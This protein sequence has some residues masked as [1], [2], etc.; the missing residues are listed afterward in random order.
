MLSCEQQNDPE[1]VAVLLPRTL[2]F[3]WTPVA[4]TSPFLFQGSND[5]LTENEEDLE[6]KSES[7]G[8]DY[9]PNKKKKKKL[10]DKKEKKA[11]R[12]RKDDDEDDNDDGC[13]KVI[14]RAR[15]Q[16]P[17]LRQG[18]RAPGW[19]WLQGGSSAS[20][21]CSKRARASLLPGWLWGADGSAGVRMRMCVHVEV[22]PNCVRNAVPRV[23]ETHLK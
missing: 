13:L 16:G 19:A 1:S 4:I 10:K 9:S 17:G 2:D 18:T 21:P 7:E 5:E 12:K 22:G 3:L 14:P 11:K 6:E 15:L 8:S 20:G 23:P